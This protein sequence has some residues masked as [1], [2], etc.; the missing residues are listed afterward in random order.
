MKYVQYFVDAVALGTL[1]ALVSLGIGLIFGVMRLVNLAHGELL[2]AGGYTLFATNEWPAVARVP[3]VL[4]VVVGLAV[5]LERVAFRRLRGASPATMLVMTFAVSFL[6]RSIAQKRWTAQ[7][8]AMNI[9]GSL[10]KAFTIGDLRIRYVTVVSIVVGG[11][12]LFAV[13]LFLNR[14]DMGLQMRAVATDGR[15]AQALGVRTDRIVVIAFAI[16]GVLATAALL[17]FVPQRPTITPD[18]GLQIAVLALIGVVIGGMDRLAPA[19]FGGFAIGFAN[20]M[21]FNLLPKGQRVFLDSALYL[22]V[23]LVLLIRPQGLFQRDRQTS[24]V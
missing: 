9:F 15:I 16:S 5:L 24:R 14:T 7:G 22:L 20:S 11:L 8:K 18:F 21:V 12:L 23:I 19:T 13:N 1:Y 2:M 10:S 4:A 3:L 6:L 17:L